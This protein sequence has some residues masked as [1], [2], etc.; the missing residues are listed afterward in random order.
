MH[1]STVNNVHINGIVT[2]QEVNED[3]SSYELTIEA[4]SIPTKVSLERAIWE[5]FQNQFPGQV[6]VSISGQLQTAKTEGSKYSVKGNSV[7]CFRNYLG[8]QAEISFDGTVKLRKKF[9]FNTDSKLFLKRLLLSTDIA[10][11]RPVTFEAM[12][13]RSCAPYFDEI[14][15]GEKLQIKAN[16]VKDD[17][18]N[19]PFWRIKSRPAVLIE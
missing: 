16:F 1:K 19:P 2:R 4:N 12:A 10:E 11:Q 15:E 9:D 14:D 17:S 6:S 3:A 8:N 13:L 18:G 5:N 7:A